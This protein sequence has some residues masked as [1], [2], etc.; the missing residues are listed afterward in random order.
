VDSVSS[1]TRHGRAEPL[2][3]HTAANLVASIFRAHGLALIRVALLLVG[4]QA[5]AEDVVQDAFLGLHRALPRLREKD[6]AVGYLRVS[7]VN[8]C[9]SVQRARRRHRMLRVEH[10][11]PVWSAESAVIAEEDR[12]AVLAALARLPQRARE[13]VALRYFLDLPQ[14]E[15]A[16]I[17]GTTRGTVSSIISRS[18][19][20]LSRDLQEER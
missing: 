5:T 9:R 11:P 7:V 18:L 13:V 12:R 10:D 15:I 8:G 17:L 19:T 6:R 20:K 16:A 14:E 4:D 3:E 1:V 2:D